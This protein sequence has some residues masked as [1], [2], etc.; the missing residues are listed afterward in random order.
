MPEDAGHFSGASLLI[1]S[2]ACSGL[3][4]MVALC[5]RRWVGLLGAGVFAVLRIASD[6]LQWSCRSRYLQGPERR[7]C[8]SLLIASKFSH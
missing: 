7:V 2:D 5:V 1:A 6:A 8:E 4:G 3:R